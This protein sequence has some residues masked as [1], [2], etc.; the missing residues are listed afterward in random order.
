MITDKTRQISQKLVLLK[1]WNGGWWLWPG[2]PPRRSG[3]GGR[4]WGGYHLCPCS[5]SYIIHILMSATCCSCSYFS[6]LLTLSH[7]YVYY[8]LSLKRYPGLSFY[9]YFLFK[10]LEKFLVLS[11]NFNFFLS[12]GRWRWWGFARRGERRNT[13]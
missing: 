12:G 9:C 13:R 10:L 3:R 4:G 6:F 8:A 5:K 11:L 7:F 2:H 1:Y